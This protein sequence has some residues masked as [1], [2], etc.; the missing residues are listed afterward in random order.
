MFF[1]VSLEELRRSGESL[2]GVAE[3]EEGGYS[4][5]LGVYHE[6]HCLVSPLATSAQQRG[7]FS[8]DT[9]QRQLRFYL[10]REI[11]YPDLTRKQEIYLFDH[12]GLSYALTQPQ[13]N[14][15]S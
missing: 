4:A 11:Y 2:D 15:P 3:V 7:N 5:T 9:S 14:L 8:S 10:F 13:S 12:L 1:N 6:L